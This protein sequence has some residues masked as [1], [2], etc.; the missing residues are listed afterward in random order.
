MEN[1]NTLMAESS[2]AEAILFFDD[3]QVVKEMT[4]AEFQAIL[5]SYVPLHDIANRNMQAVFVR[6]NHNLH[7]TGAVFFKIDFDKDGFVEKSWN[8]PLQ[9]LADNAAKGPD[10]GSG[11]IAL[12][13]YSQC[14]IGWHRN[15]LWDPLMQASLNDVVQIKKTIKNNTLGLIFEK[16][17]EVRSDD[18]YSHERTRAALL[19]KE[20]RLKQKLLST[21]A[22]Q[23]MRQLSLDH[24]ERVLAYQQQLNQYQQQLNEQGSLNLELKETIVGQNDKLAGMREYFESKIQLAQQNGNEESDDEVGALEAHYE[25]EMLLQI[26]SVKAECQAELQ[27]R[28]VELMYRG[29]RETKLKEEIIKLQQDNK[30][31]LDI[32]SDVVLERLNEAGVNF[33]IYHPGAGHLTIKATGVLSYLQNPIAY[34]AKQCSVNERLYRVWLDHF[35][36]PACQRELDNGELC[37]KLVK[38]LDDPSQFII[39]ESDCCPEHRTSTPSIVNINKNGRLNFSNNS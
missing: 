27:S 8:L 38:R 1:K 16:K 37:D 3:H 24:Q 26:D 2:S 30:K 20:Q 13:C 15:S 6:I 31:L 34:V 35:Y 9:N 14:P 11:P 25:S 33:V 5:D 7:V 36:T 10:M 22:N 29:E 39:G 17:P 21:K 4:Y 23:D 32:S 19:I 18:D 12:A 28:D